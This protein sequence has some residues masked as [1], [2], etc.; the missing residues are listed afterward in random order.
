MDAIFSAVLT[1]NS[2]K[3]AG[4]PRIENFYFM[5]Q[6][7]VDEFVLKYDDSETLDEVLC[8]HNVILDVI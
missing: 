1:K 3:K 6:D 7:E 5:D 4:P 2:T 8:H